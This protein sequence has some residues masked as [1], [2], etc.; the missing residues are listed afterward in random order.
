MTMDW[1][2]ESKQTGNRNLIWE[3]DKMPMKKILATLLTFVLVFALLMQPVSAAP[4]DDLKKEQDA[5][6]PEHSQAV[7]LKE[8]HRALEEI[9]KAFLQAKKENLSRFLS[10]LEEKA[11]QYLVRLSAEDFHGEIRLVQTAEDSTEIKLFSSNG[12]LITR[13]SGSQKTVMYISVLFAISDFT[14]E[15]R[16]EDYPLI[17]DAATSSFGDSKEKD[18]YNII[19]KLQKQC[20]I[21]TKDFLDRGVLNMSEIEQLTCT[22]YRIKKAENFDATNMA[23]VR[24]LIEKIK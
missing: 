20:I 10:E 22:V 6:D 21:V 13:P 23:T 9:Y 19:N 5:L 2:G 24:T 16:E 15:K 14:S 3:R 12:T 7:V 8:V 1:N 18:F 17:F 4:S 11:N